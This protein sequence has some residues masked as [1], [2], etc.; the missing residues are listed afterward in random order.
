MSEPGEFVRWEEMF[1][2]ELVD[3]AVTD[4]ANKGS[5]RRLTVLWILG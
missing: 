4:L 2:Q 1:R 3:T 5:P